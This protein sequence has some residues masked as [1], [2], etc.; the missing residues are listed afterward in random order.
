MVLVINL[1]NAQLKRQSVKFVKR[2]VTMQTFVEVNTG[3]KK[4][5]GDRSNNQSA[6]FTG[7]KKKNTNIH[8]VTDKNGILETTTREDIPWIDSRHVQSENNTTYSA[9]GCAKVHEA[10]KTRSHQAFTRVL[11]FPTNRIGKATSNKPKGM[12]CRLDTGADVSIMPL[13][14]YKY[15]NPSEFDEQGKPIDG[16]GQ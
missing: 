10:H 12:K 16:H 1:I 15:M 11:M 7:N 9:K 4:Q 6:K 2:L 3:K 14:T 13:S 5:N 8:L